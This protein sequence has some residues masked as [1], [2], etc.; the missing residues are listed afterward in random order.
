MHRFLSRLRDTPPADTVGPPEVRSS[1][2]VTGRLLPVTA[3]LC[4]LA[5]AVRAEP[6]T[7]TLPAEASVRDRHVR[8]ADVVRITGGQPAEAAAMAQTDL[9]LLEDPAQETVVSRERI[10]VRVLL[11]GWDHVPLVFTGAES[12]KITLE[13]TPAWTDIRIEEAIRGMLAEAMHVPQ[14][15]LQVRL[16]EPFLESLPSSVSPG[17]AFRPDPVPPHRLTLGRAAVHVRLWQGEQL[18]GS[19]LTTCTVLRRFRVPVAAAALPRLHPLSAE[20]VTLEDRFLTEPPGDVEPRLLEGRLLRQ[21]LSPGEVVTAR[22]LTPA[23]ARP[24]QAAVR[25]RDQV[26]VVARSG[27]VRVTLQSAEAL[28]SGS[29]GDV[30]RVRNVSSNNVVS[31]TVLAPGQVEIRLR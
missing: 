1:R 8:L 27:S 24:V 21:A 3:A 20:D 23:T 6:L 16:T 11:A 28:Q 19:K 17:P 9:L 2:K 5:Q 30:I 18:V 7:I 26:Q 31:G 29:V 22:G 15:D 13:E 25:P 14:D 12:V 10:R 4:L